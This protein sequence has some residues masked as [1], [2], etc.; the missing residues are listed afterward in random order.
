[1]RV[2]CKSQVLGYIKKDEETN[3]YYFIDSTRI[4]RLIGDNGENVILKI[5]DKEM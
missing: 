2:Q 3:I 5:K 4:G 1:M